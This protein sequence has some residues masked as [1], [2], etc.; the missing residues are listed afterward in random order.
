MWI[1]SIRIPSKLWV[2]SNK[3]NLRRRRKESR[4]TMSL[5]NWFSTPSRKLS[6]EKKLWR[7]TLKIFCPRNMISNLKLT[8]FSKRD[9]P[10]LM[11]VTPTSLWSTVPLSTMPFKSNFQTTS[12][13]QSIRTLRK[14]GSKSWDKKFH[15]KWWFFL[16]KFAK[17]FI[18]SSKKWWE[19]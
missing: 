10:N 8:R 5:I 6:K 11:K 16:E 1:P 7:P 4:K 14:I 17:I 2:V 9:L 18:G 19:A 3:P 13:S 12:A 15:K